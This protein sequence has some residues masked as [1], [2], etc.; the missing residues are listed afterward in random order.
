[1]QGTLRLDGGG[2]TLLIALREG[3]P[4]LE[5]WGQALPAGDETRLDPGLFE[6]AIPHGM[7]DR[8]ER[9]D[10][11]PEAGHGFTAT[12]SLAASRP[13]GGFISQGLLREIEPVE[14]GVRISLALSL[15]H[16]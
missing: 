7:L 15:I 12:P 14:D 1:M 8:G 9:L 3:R 4:Q 10:L 2:Q 16:I 5:Y 11:A 13:G 6:R